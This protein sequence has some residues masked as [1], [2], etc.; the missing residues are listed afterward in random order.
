[1]VGRGA[2]GVVVGDERVTGGWICRPASGKERRTSSRWRAETKTRARARRAASNG[3]SSL[4]HATQPSSSAS[5]VRIPA[6]GQP[7][8]P[9]AY[10]PPASASV[11]RAV[12][13]DCE[14][15]ISL[16]TST[17][18]FRFASSF[19]SSATC[20]LHT[21]L[22]TN[23]PAAPTQHVAARNARQPSSPEHCQTH[24]PTLGQHPAP[25]PG[26]RWKIPVP[27]S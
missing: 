3:V 4:P 7:R 16:S 25:L 8:P 12:S 10:R 11:R 13:A 19:S 23:T 1:M 14:L 26:Q 18:A 6:C 20:Q 5:R 2:W 22:A 24:F 9:S 21:G 17:T 27:A 15:F